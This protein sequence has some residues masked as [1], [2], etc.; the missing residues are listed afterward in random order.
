MS[1]V[2][3]QAG[4][5]KN[6]SEAGPWLASESPEVQEKVLKEYPEI[7]KDWDPFYKDRMTKIV[8]IGK[9]ISKEI[10]SKELDNLK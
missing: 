9:C 7:Q 2:F 5:I 10:I 6:I 4:S 3:E 8:F 1:Y